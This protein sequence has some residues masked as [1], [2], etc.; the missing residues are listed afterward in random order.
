MKNALLIVSIVAIIAGRLIIPTRLNFSFAGNYEA[1]AHI[2]L[3]S[4]VTIAVL[5]PKRR[6]Q[7]LGIAFVLSVWELLLVLVKL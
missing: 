1:F 7:M 4:I 5:V 6:A 3:G 2:W